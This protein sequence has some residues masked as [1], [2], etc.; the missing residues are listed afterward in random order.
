M[1]KIKVLL[2]PEGIDTLLKEIADWEKWVQERTEIFLERL[3]QEGVNVASASFKAATYDGTN[4]VSVRLERRDKGVYA[5]VATG[6]AT[7][8]IEFGTG[9]TYPDIH[10]ES[11]ENGMIRGTYG[12]GNGKKKMWG[13]YGEPGTNGVEHYNKK[14][15]QTIILTRGNPANMCMY[16]AVKN[17]EE[18]VRDVARE[19]FQ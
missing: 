2:S 19:V 17:L 16:S 9:V 3:A 13:Y 14:T 6:N 5:V 1:K 18:I 8:F 10:P 12:K 4:D 15:G 11:V 7:L